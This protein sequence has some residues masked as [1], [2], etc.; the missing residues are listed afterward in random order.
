MSLLIQG[1][2]AFQAIEQAM[3]GI[4]YRDDL[5]RR[6][7]EY[8]DVLETRKTN[9][10]SID[11]AGFAQSPPTYRNACIGVIV[12]NGPSGAEC[13]AQHRTLG[14]PLVF[15]IDGALISRW[16]ITASEEPELKER[17][18]VGDISKAF[19]VN[20]NQWEPESILRAKAIGEPL[21]PIQ[22]D[23]FDAGYMPFLEGRN[24]E[25]LDYLLKSVLTKTIG[26][27]QRVIGK[28][29]RFKELFPLTFRLIAAKV[30][31]D[32]G[33]PGGWSSDN[34]NTVL[35]AVDR[36]YN[37]QGD[38]L[39][40]ST[41]YHPDILSGMWN[42]MVNLFR[43]PNLSEDDLALIF[44]KT[45][46]TPQTRRTLGIHSTPPRVAEYIVRKLPIQELPQDKRFVLEPF[47]GH[48]RFLIAAMRRMRDLL[49]GRLSNK[50][51]HDYFMRRLVGIEIDEF[52]VEVCRLSLMLADQPN[53]NG[54]QIHNEDIFLT[55]TLER[56]LRKANILLCNPPFE[57]I[58]VSKRRQ[59][60]NPAMLIRKPAE[61]LRRILQQPPDQLGIVLPR[62]FESGNSYRRFHRELAENYAN[63]EL[64][65][66][67]KV[68]NYS[69]I[70]TMLLIASGRKTNY[71]QVAVACRQVDEGYQR[72]AFL[73]YGAEPPAT[74]GTFSD[75]EI[76]R[77]GFS[78]WIPRLSRV[79]SHLNGLPHLSALLDEAHRGLM[80][81]SS[82]GK[83]DKK[84]ED[85]ISP[86]E[87][88]GYMEG[89]TRVRNH[90]T[91]YGFLREPHYL[92]IRQE[93]QYDSA[94]KHHWHRPK[95]VCNGARLSRGAWRI[96]AAVDSKGMAFSQR[97]LAMWPKKGV[98]HYAIAGLLNSPISNAF[99]RS[100][101][102]D[103]DNR[104]KTLKR[105][106]IPSIDHFQIGGR[107]D[108]LSRELHR[109]VSRRRILD[110]Y[111]CQ[112][113][114]QIDADLLKAYALPPILER[115]LLDT[116]QSAERP[117]LFRFNG[118]YPKDFDAYI[119]LSEI[120]SPTFEDAKA[121]QLLKRL[122]FVNDPVISEAMAMLHA[123]QLDGGLPH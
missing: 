47:A 65:G 74:R 105:L 50:Q 75:Q 20:Q 90:L 25:K 71:T 63:I 78:L 122:T 98:S 24:F 112:I 113:A 91:Q 72:Q 23:F 120:I 119:P 34:V 56:E 123:E 42:A 7:Y 62:S 11:L 107:L 97:F 51:R 15:E 13:V 82:S 85:F 60:N 29:P 81:I 61:L 59:Y 64:I 36:H 84:Q 45:F 86:K 40:S 35:E 39:K 114:L 44:E 30:F 110:E 108:G 117:I 103:R 95:V 32:R 6:N 96:G 66:L 48:G 19:E 92:S 38:A 46:I 69:D 17:I 1:N 21:E 80:W 33:Y 10:R 9:I 28:K 111:G 77:P 76:S 99:F 2:P 121:E 4:G 88:R 73:Q 68:F 52:S 3:R 109:L 116:F 83:S 87:K 100:M 93:D 104:L 67:P 106:P 54:W 101:D 79:W 27:H 16:K 12:S 14:A 94:F 37:V 57:D 22:L 102:G 70:A 118:Y 8:A 26:I 89:Y 55:D 41:I 49:P 115:E 58:S 5:L 31:R 18:P 53:P 43:F